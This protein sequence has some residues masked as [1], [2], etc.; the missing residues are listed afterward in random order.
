MVKLEHTLVSTAAKAIRN[1]LDPA[2]VS[3]ALPLFPRGVTFDIEVIEG[4]QCIRVRAE[5][6]DREGSGNWVTIGSRRPFLPGAKG[7]HFTPDFW[8]KANLLNFF[9]DALVSIMK[10]ELAEVLHLDGQMVKDPHLDYPGD[11]FWSLIGP[12]PHPCPPCLNPC[13]NYPPPKDRPIVGD[14]LTGCPHNPYKACKY[15]KHDKTSDPARCYFPWDSTIVKTQ[16]CPSF[17]SP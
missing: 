1:P 10:H 11:E 2:R 9:E 13:L 12:K 14:P 17:R 7:S 4:V 15:S 8:S 6:L 3:F 16:L 5:V